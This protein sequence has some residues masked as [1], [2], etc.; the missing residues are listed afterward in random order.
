MTRK[1]KG[2]WELGSCKEI[3]KI[4]KNRC[5][6]AKPSDSR[7]IAHLYWRLPLKVNPPPY[8][9]I[10]HPAVTTS[11]STRYT[12]NN[13]LKFSSKHKT[14]QKGL[15][16][17]DMTF[18]HDP[19]VLGVEQRAWFRGFYKLKAQKL[20][21]TLRNKKG[22]RFL[23]LFGCFCSQNLLNYEGFALWNQSITYRNVFYL[24]K[25]PNPKS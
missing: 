9:T 16:C 23:D 3:R 22:H 1:V 10:Q 13:S 15:A 2:I 20:D 24:Q 8:A 5:S 4:N 19:S 17:G 14:N 25:L 12:R 21:W 18:H 7:E 6:G 11:C